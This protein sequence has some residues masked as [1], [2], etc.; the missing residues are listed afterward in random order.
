MASRGVDILLASAVMVPRMR[1]SMG[2]GQD[3]VAAGG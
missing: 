1:Q 3:E 2:E